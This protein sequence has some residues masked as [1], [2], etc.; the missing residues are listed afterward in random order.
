M[1]LHTYL[2]VVVK[3][4]YVC[5]SI[6]WGTENMCVNSFSALTSIKFRYRQYVVRLSLIQPHCMVMYQ[7]ELHF[8]FVFINC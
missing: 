1:Y 3:L 8:V 2:P 6:I 7:Y 4:G 5:Q